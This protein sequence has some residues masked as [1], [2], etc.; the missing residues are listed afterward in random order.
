M[1]AVVE[2]QAPERV[3]GAMAER[4][5]LGTRTERGDHAVMGDAAER[6]DSAQIRHFRNTCCEK[7]AAG[8]ELHTGWLVQRWQA[9]HRISDAG[10]DEFESI[11]R[12]GG[13][14]AAGEAETRERIVEEHP[15]VIAGERAAGAV[16]AVHSRR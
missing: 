15:G 9:A 11:A 12:I 2:P 1:V 16:G 14:G 10:V 4:G 3:R 8:C 5:V 6:D 13:I 7:F